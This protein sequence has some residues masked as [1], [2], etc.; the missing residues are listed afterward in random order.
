M[1]VALLFAGIASS[2]PD[3]FLSAFDARTGDVDDSLS[4]PIASNLFD[5][6]IAFGLPIFLYTAM[7]GDIRF[8]DM[9]NNIYE[10]IY[11]L[12]IIM[13]II[14]IVFLVSVLFSKRYSLLHAI[15]FF[16]LFISFIFSLFYL[17]QVYQ[18][19]S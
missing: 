12:V 2:I 1:F 9:H 17:D 10:D 5:I 19:F 14:T 13:I 7:K 11:S 4:N 3:L 6:C 18:F 15:L 16:I 8:D